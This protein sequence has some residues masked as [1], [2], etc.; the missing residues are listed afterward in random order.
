M[1]ANAQRRR[2]S[3]MVEISGENLGDLQ[4]GSPAF[5]FLNSCAFKS[6]FFSKS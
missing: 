2:D 1:G 3:L 4:F 5:D 6:C